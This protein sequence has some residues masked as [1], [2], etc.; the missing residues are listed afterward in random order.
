METDKKPRI[1][2]VLPGE[3][4]EQSIVIDLPPDIWL[5]KVTGEKINPGFYKKF[6]KVVE[7][8]PPELDVEL[9]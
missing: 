4:W 9:D 5:N 6:I 1:F 3:G 7:I 2:W 8:M